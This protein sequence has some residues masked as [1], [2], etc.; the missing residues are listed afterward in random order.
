MVVPQ[1]A[2]VTGQEG[3]FVF[4]I[5]GDGTVEK[6]PVK[7]DRTVDGLAVV[8]GELAAGQ[9]VVTDGQMRLMPGAKVELKSSIAASAPAAPSAEKKGG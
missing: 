1:A 6:R 5:K 8:Q 9:Q 4:V 3:T 7:V 2:V